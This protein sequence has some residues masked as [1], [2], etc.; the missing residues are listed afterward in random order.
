MLTEDLSLPYSSASRRGGVTASRCPWRLL[1]RRPA[2]PS[3]TDARF[4][5]N[6]VIDSRAGRSE[7]SSRR[8]LRALREILRVSAGD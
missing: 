2:A 6:S 1:L 3:L 4:E 8:P 7:K 5:K